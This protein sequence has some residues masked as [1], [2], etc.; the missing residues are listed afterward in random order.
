MWCNKERVESQLCTN[1]IDFDHKHKNVTTTEKK[2]F[3]ENI[4]H[5]LTMLN[6]S[7]QGIN[8]NFQSVNSCGEN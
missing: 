7:K 8:T 3:A 2:T 1:G 5:D 6:L 4:D